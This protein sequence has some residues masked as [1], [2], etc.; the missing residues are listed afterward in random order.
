MSKKINVID[1]RDLRNIKIDS[2]GSGELYWSV[3]VYAPW[4]GGIKHTPP[5]YKVIGNPLE[6]N[7]ATLTVLKKL[8]CF[9]EFDDYYEECTIKWFWNDDGIWSAEECIFEKPIS[10]TNIDEI[11]ESVLQHLNNIFKELNITF[12]SGSPI[13]K[14]Q[15][16]TASAGAYED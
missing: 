10:N 15:W 4:C 6:C 11:Q 13:T 16:S 2:V 8:R 14:K 5:D 12:S 3:H 9:V 7:E 1:L